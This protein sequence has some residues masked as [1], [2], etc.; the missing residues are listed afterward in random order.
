MRNQLL[1]TTRATDGRSGARRRLRIGERVPEI[2]SG[3]TT[4]NR[5]ETKQ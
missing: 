4:N 5:K 3:E 2:V 1:I